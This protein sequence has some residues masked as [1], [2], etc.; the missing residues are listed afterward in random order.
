MKFQKSLLTATLFTA[1]S[2]TAISANATGTDTGNFKILL[3]VESTCNLTAGVTSDIDLGTV[4]DG[5]TKTG[6]N[7]IAVACSTG[8]L[9]K[10]GLKPGDDSAG[11]IGVL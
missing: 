4:K 1:A 7:N 9:Y 5:T 11:G 8:T 3:T 2:L 10:V 6:T